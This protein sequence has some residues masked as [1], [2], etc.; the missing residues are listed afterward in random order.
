MDD[1]G[2]V[3]LLDSGALDG[4]SPTPQDSGFHCTGCG[5]DRPVRYASCRGRK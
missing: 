3:A 5:P 1:G 4:Q 2:I